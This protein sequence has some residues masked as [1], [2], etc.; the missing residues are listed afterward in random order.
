M[1]G[2]K[3]PPFD[4]SRPGGLVFSEGSASPMQKIRRRKFGEILVAEG[5]VTRD[6]LQDALR[7]QHGSGLTLGEI[8]LH[9][10]VITEGD[11]VRCLSS[12][13]QLPFIRTVNYDYETSLLNT[14]G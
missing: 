5:L 7:R 3:G 12:Q 2:S 11:I 13:Y 1:E 4:G 10:G 9:D 8:L 6:I 14:F